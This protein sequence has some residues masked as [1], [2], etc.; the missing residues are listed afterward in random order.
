MISYFN[1]FQNIFFKLNFMIKN[2]ID[3]EIS[4]NLIIFYNKFKNSDSLKQLFI[5]SPC[6]ATKFC[7]D[8]LGFY[9]DYSKNY[10][11]DF[12]LSLL[13]KIADEKKVAEKIDAMF[14]GAKINTTEN[15]A[16]LHTALRD[17]DNP[18]YVY[19][20]NDV[21]NAT[22][23]IRQ[24]Q[25]KI[26]HLCRQLS[27]NNLLGFSGKPI[28]TI[29]N[30]GIGGSDLGP[31]MAYFA[32]RPYWNNKIRCHFVSNIDPYEIN[33]VLEQSNPETTMF[34]LSSKSFTTYETL[35]NAQTARKW[36]LK[37][38]SFDQL[39][40]HF[41]AVTSAVDKAIKFGID[42]DHILPI[43]D[44]V[45][46]RFSLW[47]A[48]GISIALG[49]SYETYSELL[50]GAN[51]LDNHFKSES[52]SNNIPVILALLGIGYINFANAT[53]QALLPYSQALEYFPSYIQQLDMESN[54]KSVDL[55]DNYIDYKTGPII[56]GAPGTNGQHAF[57]QL[58]HQGTHLVPCD[59][60]V[61]INSHYEPI[62]QQQ[63]LVANALAQA[64]TLLHGTNNSS[65][66]VIANHKKIL[67][68]K[69]STTI[70]F[71]KLT[72][73][74]LGILIA[75][76]EHKV[77]TQGIIWGINSFDQW[78]VE[79]G[80]VSAIEILEYLK[81]QNHEGNSKFDASTSH[82]IDICRQKNQN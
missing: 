29:V 57:H 22:D 59:F 72:P 81:L 14:N 16:V 24:T 34:V 68:N 45:G 6:R 51:R 13:L 19:E 12:S 67:G 80:K 21:V 73:Y 18:R 40:Y 49:T 23:A 33:M 5:N 78:G 66:A 79:S 20:N 55:M 26:L 82:L 38:C 41:I 76:Y 52:W 28:D 35:S 39:K 44:F 64:K 4:R 10:I 53:S 3:D 42:A 1:Q 31:K 27:S 71:D 37:F 36:L 43:W 11:D 75:I 25:N 60:I 47:S 61:P 7:I 70:L 58:L 54:G 30:I 46:G 65:D 2:F 17:L 69:P 8:N 48:I 77:F 56:W 50:K 15:R 9:I 74:N 62:E 63:A 32:L